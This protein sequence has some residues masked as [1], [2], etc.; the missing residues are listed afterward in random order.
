VKK[1]RRRAGD[2]FISLTLSFVLP[3][4]ALLDAEKKKR[5]KKKKKLCRQNKN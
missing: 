5:K 2:Y 3:L 1:E 4:L